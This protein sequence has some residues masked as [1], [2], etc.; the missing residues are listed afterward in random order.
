MRASA[1]RLDTEP[2]AGQAAL[3]GAVVAQSA[4]DDPNAVADAALE[5]LAAGPEDRVL[6]LGCGSGRL[7]LRL[8]ARVRRG[9][10]VGIDPSPLMVR[11]ARHRNRG[12]IA[13]GRAQIEQGCSRD[14]SRFADASFDHVLGVHVVCFWSQP[15][16]DLAEVRRVLRPGGRLLLGFRPLG[17]GERDG[18]GPN[19]RVAVAR[20][21]RWLRWA[22]F[23]VL[24]TVVRGAPVHPLAWVRAR[25]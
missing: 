11:H 18:D 6:E 21:E 8:A 4:T 9:R 2:L 17:P 24:D 16:R 1:L 22:G 12:W 23:D 20:V 19:V 25:R 13:T 5:R 15:A 3:L 10:V 7:L 14:L